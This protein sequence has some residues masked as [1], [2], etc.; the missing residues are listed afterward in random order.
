[1]YTFLNKSA[2]ISNDTLDLQGAI[3]REKP[4]RSI[5][6]TISWRTIGTIDTFIL[7][8]LLTGSFGIA[9]SIGGAELITK[10][11]LYYFHERIW[12]YLKFGREVSPPLE[13][14]I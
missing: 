9:A 11:I 1:M 5:V 2:K 6:K 3:V 12:N 7:S 4:Y 13:Y 14:E 8:F 10:M